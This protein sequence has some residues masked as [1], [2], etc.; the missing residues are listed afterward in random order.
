[1]TQDLKMVGNDYNKALM[2]FFVPYIL[3]E[4]PSNILI[5]R[6]APSTWI[7]AL[8]TCWGIVTI[9][10]GLI[11]SK[12]SLLAMRFL[13]GLFEAGFFP[14]YSTVLIHLSMNNS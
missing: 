11:K 8:M 13:L 2:I 10:Q 1:M 14:G 4:V 12:E 6:I 3:F 7:S 9:G 5:K